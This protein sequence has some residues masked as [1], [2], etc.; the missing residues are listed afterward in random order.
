M[1]FQRAAANLVRSALISFTMCLGCGGMQERSGEDYEVIHRTQS[2]VDPDPVPREVVEKLKKCVR[3][4]VGELA[5]YSHE[6]RFIAGLTDEGVVTDVGVEKSTIAGDA[7]V[8]CMRGTLTGTSI[9]MSVMHARSSQFNSSAEWS[10]ESR[11][12]LGI[13]Q[14]LGGV[15]AL[16]PIMLVAA[17]AT[18]AVYVTAT[19]IEAVAK[20][21]Q[22]EKLCMPWLMQC[23]G[24]KYQPNWNIDDFGAQKDCQGC[25]EECK[26]KSGLWPD[27]KCP[28]SGYRP[29]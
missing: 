24:D 13:A 28:R 6:L 2:I 18:I 23:L 7:I 8:S 19:T 11:E 4:N 25:F 20:W 17:G 21:R 29:N 16:G 22:I 14:A 10:P 9:V 26:H 27:Y 1:E 3:D 12:S 5:T 15:V